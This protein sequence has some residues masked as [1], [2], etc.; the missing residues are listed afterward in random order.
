MRTISGQVMVAAILAIGAIGASG[1]GLADD[2]D[3]RACLVQEDCL[4]GYTCVATVCT[5][6][7][8]DA[9]VSATD[10]GMTPLPDASTDL[11]PAP[12]CTD[13]VRNGHETDIDCGGSCAPCAVGLQCAST[14]DCATGTCEG[15]H[16]LAGR[17]ASLAGMPTPRQDL[18]AVFGPDGRLYALGGISQA[19]G[20][21]A[22]VEAYNPTNNSWTTLAPMANKR[23]GFAAA[24]GSDGR[25]YAIGGSY[26]GQTSPFSDGISKTVE[27]YDPNTNQW[28]P[29]AS[30]STSR[31]RGAAVATANGHLYAFGGFD[32]SVPEQS[33]STE[34]YDLASNK[35][36]PLSF[37]MTTGR[38]GHAGAVAADGRVF[39]FGGIND[40]SDKLVAVESFTPGTIG[41]STAPPMPTPRAWLAAARGSDNRLYA[42]GGN[43]FSSGPNSQPSLSV[44]EAFSTSANAWTKVASMPT[45][46]YA[47]AAVASPDGKIYAIGGTRVGSFANGTELPTLEVFTPSP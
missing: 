22:V 46:R 18:A 3:K 5:L 14:N 17:W 47:L 4:A 11:K 38:S 15:D 36:S 16:C 19:A 10:G 25:I 2:P 41:W 32:Y 27:A 1:C 20:S 43:N 34:S 23:Y 31:Y 42:I 40:Q 30:L 35:W 45:D 44:V 29:V 13:H 8:P 6:D 28:K 26:Q 21:L 39:A 12:S 9:D 33:T 7:S 24:V 37:S